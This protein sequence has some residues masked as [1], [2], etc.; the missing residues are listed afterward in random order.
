MRS[1]CPNWQYCQVE[2][3]R[4]TYYVIALYWL[5]KYQNIILITKCHPVFLTLTFLFGSLGIASTRNCTLF[6]KIGFVVAGSG[7]YSYYIHQGNISDKERKNCKYYL[8]FETFLKDGCN[9]TST[10]L[11]I[12]LHSPPFHNIWQ[13]LQVWYLQSI[14]EYHNSSISL[15]D[16][17][18]TLVI[19]C[20]ISIILKEDTAISYQ[21]AKDI[22]EDLGQVITLLFNSHK[23][24]KEKVF[25]I[26]D[27]LIGAYKTSVSWNSI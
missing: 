7:F 1:H 8:R 16:F 26:I 24:D 10:F 15:I 20:N 25:R 17:L 22:M 4:Y 27:I 13:L 3:L 2:T 9:S 6:L 19:K 11:F 18:S 21:E 23:M 5:I 14:W 12:Y